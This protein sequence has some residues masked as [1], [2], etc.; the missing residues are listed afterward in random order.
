MS[1]SCTSSS[2]ARRSTRIA[3]S[4]SSGGPQMPSPVM[5]MA[6]KPRRFTSRSPNL[7]VPALLAVV[8][9]VMGCPY[10]SRP[11]GLSRSPLAWRAADGRRPSPNRVP[12][13]RRL[14]LP[15][16]AAQ[17]RE[18][19]VRGAHLRTG[20]GV[21]GERRGGPRPGKRPCPAAL[22]LAAGWWPAWAMPGR[23][24]VLPGGVA[25]PAVGGG[26]DRGHGGDHAGR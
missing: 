7:T 6:P 9:W 12:V 19:A 16:P 1:I 17:P 14:E 20:G 23:G 11:V 13:L 15:R 5:R 2:T 26:A 3:S 4:R 10:P 24:G 25:R 8:V 18:P 21:R 22:E